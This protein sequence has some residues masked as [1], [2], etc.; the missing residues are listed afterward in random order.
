MA[1]RILLFSFLIFQVSHISAQ[2]RFTISGYIKDELNGEDLPGANIYDESSLKGTVTNEYGFYSITLPQGKYKL[3]FSYLGYESSSE[4]VDLNVNIRLN[5]ELGPIAYKTEEVVISA[6]KEDRNIE[7]ADMGLFELKPEQA[8][9]I[10]ALLGETDVLRTL[11]LLP[12]VQ[13]GSELNS[14]LYVRGGGPDQNLI[15]LD[16]AVVY[17]TGH[18]FGFYSVFNPD[19]IKSVKL[20][21]GGMPANYGGRLSSVVDVVMKEGNMK[22]I[23]VEGGIGLISSRLTVQ[24]PLKKNKA[25]FL[26]SGRRTYIDLLL[27]PVLNNVND[28]DFKGNTYY[29]YDLNAKFNYRFSDKDRLFLSGY[30]GRDKFRFKSPDDGFDIELPWGNRTATLRWNH[31]FSDKLFMNTMLLY[32]DYNFEVASEF[33]DVLFELKSGVRDFNSKIEFDYYP[34]VNHHIRFG[35][36]YTY[37]IFTPYSATGS[38]GDADFA[39]SSVSKKY[40]HESA[41]YI[42]DD[43]DITTWLK[44]NAGLRF[45]MFNHVGPLEKLVVNELGQ[46]EDTIKFERGDI[47]ETYYGVEPRLNARI[48]ID[49][50]SSVKLGFTYNKQYIHLVSSSTTTL[51]SDLWVPST[52]VV[53]PQIGYQLSAGYFRNFKDNMFETSVEVYY[54][55]L[56]NQIEYG[57]S[58]VPD[59]DIDL[60]DLFV[61]GKGES[62]GIE[63]FVNKTKGDLTG[64]VGYTLSHTDK[65]FPDLN[66]GDKFPAKYDRRHDLSVVVSYDISPKWIVSSTF[67]YATGQATTVP[68]GRYIIGGQLVNQY[69]DR[70]GYRLKPYHRLEFSATYDM[71]RKKRE[72]KLIISVYNVYSRK[73]PF[74]IY[75]DIEGSLDDGDLTVTPKQVSLFPI[76]PSLTWDFKF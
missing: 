48:K 68:V 33:N 17:N 2:D 37:H 60:E 55:N 8:K 15:Q 58:T 66:D 28:G 30:F 49:D 44:V 72:S 22:K 25:S 35:S 29:F 24:G 70:N 43:F 5:K 6:E 41:I 53:K 62:Y 27:K 50:R 67:I 12:G 71:Q 47:I 20:I 7:G 64:W 51:P 56:R 18:L 39:T 57:E 45:T 23:E 10:P 75:Y 65:E 73:N 38:S 4:E 3:I 69:G 59:L 46:A 31:L 19:A 11:Q 52:Q 76:L 42:L 1:I 13:S 40:A 63:F 54:K 16:N 61:F 14:G 32:N 21:K 26:V 34:H 36:N 74:F 9:K